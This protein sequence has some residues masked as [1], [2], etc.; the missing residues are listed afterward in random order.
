VAIGC[1]PLILF[2]LS[3]STD[4]LSQSANAAPGENNV[5]AIVPLWQAVT[6]ND[7]RFELV[8]G[9]NPNDGEHAEVSGALRAHERF[10][11]SRCDRFDFDQLVAEP[12]VVALSVPSA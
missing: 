11:L 7:P 3:S 8:I 9:T 12:A 5:R 6:P 2:C 10:S 4:R 1:A